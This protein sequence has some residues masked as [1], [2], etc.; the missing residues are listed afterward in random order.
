MIAQI[1]LVNGPHH[2]EIVSIGTTKGEWPQEI[3]VAYGHKSE[4]ADKIDASAYIYHS[5]E[6]WGG[7]MML[8][9]YVYVGIKPTA[10]TLI[11]V[12][13]HKLGAEDGKHED[14]N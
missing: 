11:T 2:D 7:T 8:G 12:W 13:N 4:T 14:R 5:V 9:S 6:A 10:P 1:M 3:R